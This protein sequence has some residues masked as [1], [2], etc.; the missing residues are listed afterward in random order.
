MGRF[1]RARLPC[2]VKSISLAISFGKI[3]IMSSNRLFPYG[4]GGRLDTVGNLSSI[5][6][7]RCGLQRRFVVFLEISLNSSDRSL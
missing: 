1:L 7:P 5:G 3:G 4:V 2:A 6:W